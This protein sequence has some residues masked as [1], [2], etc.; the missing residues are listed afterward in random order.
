M[1]TAPG[2]LIDVAPTVLALAGLPRSRWPPLAGRPVWEGEAT[3]ERIAEQYVPVLLGGEG[4]A[5]V[6]DLE[7]LKARR[8]SWSD[9]A[10]KLHQR[11]GSPPVILD[12]AADPSEHQVLRDAPGRARAERGLE[13]W[14]ERTGIRWP[15]TLGAGPEVGGWRAEALKALGYVE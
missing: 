8:R 13:A 2:R 11:E 12:L 10:I 1:G 7:T 3:D 14:A 15:D 9:G 5:L 6:G 4:Q